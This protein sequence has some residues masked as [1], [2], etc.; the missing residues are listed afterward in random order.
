MEL[1]DDTANNEVKYEI[2]ENLT[3]EFMDD[4]AM[5]DAAPIPQPNFKTIAG[6]SQRG[7]D[8]LI[9]SNGY[10]FNIKVV[11]GATTYWQC[12]SRSK[13]VNCRAT[14]VNHINKAPARL[15]PRIKNF[16]QQANRLRSKNMPVEPTNSYFELNLDHVSNNFL[17][18]DFMVKENSAQLTDSMC[19]QTIKKLKNKIVL[20]ISNKYYNFRKQ[21]I[22]KDDTLYQQCNGKFRLII[23]DKLTNSI[24]DHYHNSKLYCYSGLT[25]CSQL[26]KMSNNGNKYIIN[27]IDYYSS[28][29]EN[30]A[31]PDIT[32]KTVTTVLNKSII[33]KYG[34]PIKIYTYMGKQ[35]DCS[36]IKELC[37]TFGIKKTNSH[38]YQHNENVEQA[39]RIIMEKLII[40]CT[41]EFNDWDE[42]LDEIVYSFRALPSSRT[43][44]SPLELLFGERD[45][46]ALEKVNS[47]T[48]KYLI[49]M[50]NNFDKKVQKSF[51]SHNSAYVPNVP[52]R[53]KNQKIYKRDPRNCSIPKRLVNYD[54]TT[55]QIKQ[56]NNIELL[57]DNI[58]QRLTDYIDSLIKLN[59]ALEAT[60]NNDPSLFQLIH[61]YEFMIDHSISK[62][63]RIQENLDI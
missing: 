11:R 59:K 5:A 29:L 8:K 20:D 26:I 36:L 62:S 41:T 32:A 15:L 44:I 35:F 45:D 12:I 1:I 52:I 40:L 21:L 61:H 30:V 50:K 37:D 63:L 27:M 24:I 56:N 10:S 6:S 14:V 53:S 19:Q 13:T 34:P 48:R 17:K 18:K 46:N 58:H 28:R 23:P 16:D 42:K 55:N 2:S 9:D 7:K 38:P 4:E 25:K 49:S 47:Y 51:S 31:V 43:G 57:Y 39:N 22:I 3:E 33:L 54:L 60:N